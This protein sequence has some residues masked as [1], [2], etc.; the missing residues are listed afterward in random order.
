MHGQRNIKITYLL[1][2]LLTH[3]FTP[4]CRVILEQLTVS[5]ASQ[6]IPRIVWNPNV[7]YRTHKCPYPEPPRSSP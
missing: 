2:D 5:S 3:L 4:W 1:T 6:E 7:H